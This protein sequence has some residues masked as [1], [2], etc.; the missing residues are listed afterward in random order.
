M[1]AGPACVLACVLTSGGLTSPA[2]SAPGENNPEDSTTQN[3]PVVNASTPAE[4]PASAAPTT[5]AGF[6][7][8]AGAATPLVMN[9]SSAQNPYYGS[10][11]QG[12]ATAETLPL[13]L[14]EAV[15]RGIQA[16]LAMAEATVAEQQAQ[17]QRLESLNALMP[18]IQGQATTAA[19]QINLASFG[20]T[21][22]AIVGIG[23]LFPGISLAGFSPIVKFDTTQVDAALDWT[24][25][26]Y[27]AITRYKAAKENG[28]AAYYSTRSSRGL[29]V[30][31]VGN[32]YLQ[33]L[34]DK[35]QIDSTQALERADAL[36]LQQAQAEHE[37]GTVARLDELRARVQYQTQQQRVIAAQ[38][39]YQ[40]DL[41]LLKREIGVPVEQPIAL[42][43]AAPYEDLERMPL[44][45]AEREAYQN[46]QD[47]QGLQRQLRAAEL[48]RAAAR[49]ERLPTVTASGNFG[50]T[51]VTQGPYHGTFIALGE[52]KL[53]L[54]KEAKFRGDADVAEAQKTAALDQLADLKRQIEQQLR[55][56]MLDLNSSSELVK[57]SQQNVELATRALSDANDRFVAGIE[58]NLPVVQAQ[59]TLSQAQAQLISDTLQYNQAKLGLAR[60]LGIV[61]TQYKAYLHG[62]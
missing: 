24:A 26:D 56:S 11:T 44:E 12:V 5:S 21:S 35:S 37:A 32:Q 17:A 52:V 62:K 6:S 8:N 13:S 50:I 38:N 25:F 1:V 36:L 3:T 55:D 59:A 49:Y 28:K 20:F 10:I 23:R 4:P 47:Y 19:H 40:K 61:D 34:A 14:E 45:D 15:E 2:Q 18:T 22:N 33:T 41:I 54:F 31:T 27:A 57:V 60:N 9:P 43:D 51:G 42:T 29:V 58:D 7:A 16:N 46:R 53:P 39:T 30:L 48:T